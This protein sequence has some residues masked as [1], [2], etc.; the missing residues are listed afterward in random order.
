VIRR[1]LTGTHLKL[2]CRMRLTN[3]KS[4]FASLDFASNQ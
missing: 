1:M 2:I 3:L 4:C